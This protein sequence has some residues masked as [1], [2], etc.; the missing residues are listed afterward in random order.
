MQPDFAKVRAA[1]LRMRTPAQ[2]PA[3]LD[4]I[5]SAPVHIR[6]APIHMTLPAEDATRRKTCRKIY[7]GMQRPAFGNLRHFDHS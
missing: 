1:V 6:P 2:T 3:A 7:P 4:L 5:A